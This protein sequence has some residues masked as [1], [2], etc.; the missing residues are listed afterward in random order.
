MKKSNMTYRPPPSKEN[1][2]QNSIFFEEWA[3]FL[4]LVATVP[5]KTLLVGDLNFH[6]DVPDDVDARRF[7]DTVKSVSL[8][9]LVKEPT[10]NKCQI[11]DVV[12]TR[13][14]S[15]CLSC[16]SVYDPK[17]SDNKGHPSGDHFAVQFDTVFR[18]PR[19]VTKHVTYRK[20]KDIDIEQFKMDILHDCLHLAHYRN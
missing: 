3:S 13:D 20:T 17:L 4:P 16:I 5:C 10:H 6:R 19:P 7:M 15:D 11:L 14:L 9:Q 2:L 8:K 1:G 18:K 12:I